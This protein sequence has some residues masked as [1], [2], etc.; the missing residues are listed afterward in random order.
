[1]PTLLPSPPAAPR[2]PAP[3]A[4]CSGQPCRV[5]HVLRPQTNPFGLASLGA[6]HK[7]CRSSDQEPL[8]KRSNL[9][10]NSLLPTEPM[11]LGLRNSIMS[12]PNNCHTW[13]SASATF[14]QSTTEMLRATLQHGH[15]DQEDVLQF[16]LIQLEP[17]EI[18]GLCSWHFL[19]RTDWPNVP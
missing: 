14:V 13:I 9:W 19:V 15:R 12:K 18:G 4:L 17:V 7:L 16:E 1:M 8:A 10:T 11:P 2:N 6:L 3:A 5:V